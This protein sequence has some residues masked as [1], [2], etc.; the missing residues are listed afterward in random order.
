MSVPSSLF[1]RLPGR[2]AAAQKRRQA[3]RKA[4]AGLEFT[5]AELGNE[6]Q[7]LAD[8]SESS[9]HDDAAA[10]VRE[11]TATSRILDSLARGEGFAAALSDDEGARAWR[12]LAASAGRAR[13]L[14]QGPH[15]AARLRAVAGECGRLQQLIDDELARL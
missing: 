4:L 2:K 5:A 10:V 8:I 13:L 7:R 6:L 14:G 15:R 1:G 12:E 9:E 11:T 3:H